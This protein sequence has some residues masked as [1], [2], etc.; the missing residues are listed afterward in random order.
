M[1]HL[2]QALAA[3][4]GV[5]ITGKVM[6][7][8]AIDAP[9]ETFDVVYAANLLHHIPDPFIA[10]REMLALRQSKTISMI[11]IIGEQLKLLGIAR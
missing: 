11:H 8:M 4:Y 3:K 9:D 10:V 2:A 6:N 1:V 5:S 7:A